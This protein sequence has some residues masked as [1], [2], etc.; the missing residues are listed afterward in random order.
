MKGLLIKDM[1][2]LKNQKQFLS[3]SVLARKAMI[4]PFVITY[5]TLMF[6]IFALTR[7]PMMNMI[8]EQPF[9]YAAHQQADLRRNICWLLDHSMD[10]IPPQRLTRTL[11]QKDRNRSLQA[12]ADHGGLLCNWFCCSGCN[13]T[14]TV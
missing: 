3:L 12:V 8:M 5:M 7:S 9:F 14:D 10:R 1:K 13:H 11:F 6:S 4:H 2:L